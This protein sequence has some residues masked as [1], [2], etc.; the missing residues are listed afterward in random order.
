VRQLGLEEEEKMGGD[1]KEDV[2]IKEKVS[3]VVIRT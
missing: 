1:R 2:R 3:K